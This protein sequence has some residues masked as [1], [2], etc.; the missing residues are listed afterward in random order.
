M[1]DRLLAVEDTPSIRALLE[2]CLIKGGYAVDTAEDGQAAVDLFRSKDYR[3]VVMD[4]QMPV[5][6]GLTAVGLMRA[7]ERDTSRPAAPIFA[8][9][10]NCEA[11]DV[12]RHAAA[13]FTGTVKK[14]FGREDLLK[15]IAAALGR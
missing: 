2:L 13:G 12:R 4:L 9:T 11:A 10:A 14:P 3:A 15:T 6:D 8:L 1:S 7:H 5:M